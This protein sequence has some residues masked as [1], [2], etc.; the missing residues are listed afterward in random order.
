MNELRLLFYDVFVV[1]G[2]GRDT[3]Q[4]QQHSQ[5]VFVF[6]LVALAFFFKKIV[7]FLFGRLF[8]PPFCFVVTGFIDCRG[9]ACRRSIYFVYEWIVFMRLA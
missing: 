9:E 3:S 8:F 4:R 6:D 1:N 5:F 2:S 7:L